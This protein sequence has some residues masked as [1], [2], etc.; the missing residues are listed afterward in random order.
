[1]ML[2]NNDNHSQNIL[3]KI[4]LSPAQRLLVMALL[5]MLA[6]AVMAA[7]TAAYQQ[8]QIGNVSVGVLINVFLAMFVSIFSTA[9]YHYV[10]QHIQDELQALRD[11]VTQYRSIQLPIQAPTQSPLVVIHA[12]APV[13]A[14]TTPVAP[15]NSITD[16]EAT[17]PMKDVQSALQSAIQQ[18]KQLPS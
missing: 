6:S 3:D 2:R 8:Y 17:Q 16:K 10:P 7:F 15:S 5:S 9:L 12:Q 11:M 18:S 13:V 1:M 4:K 14:P